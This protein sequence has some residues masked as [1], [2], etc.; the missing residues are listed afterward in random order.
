[1]KMFSEQELDEFLLTDDYADPI[2]TE[3]LSG[4]NANVSSVTNTLSQVDLTS[5]Q[6]D[7]G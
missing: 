4:I 2:P 6:S 1:M 7:G 3:A 5:E